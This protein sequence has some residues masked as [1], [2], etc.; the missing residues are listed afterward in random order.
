[1]GQIWDF[2]GTLGSTKLP[3][4]S[5]R[6]LNETRAR[7]EFYAKLI[8]IKILQ[9]GARETKLDSS[10]NFNILVVNTMWVICNFSGLVR[11][12]LPIKIPSRDRP[13]IRAFALHKERAEDINYFYSAKSHHPGLTLLNTLPLSAC[14]AILTLSM[15][16]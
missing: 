15:A 11:A 9:K 1:M 5:P 4:V 7:L 10:C 12:A 14:I 3:P 6:Q 2:F 13:G 16:S 8:I